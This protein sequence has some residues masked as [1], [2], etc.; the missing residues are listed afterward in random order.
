MKKNQQQQ[1]PNTYFYSKKVDPT[2]SMHTGFSQYVRM[3]IIDKE[4]RGK[5][6]III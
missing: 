1:N 4:N 6:I 2:T 5:R 3:E